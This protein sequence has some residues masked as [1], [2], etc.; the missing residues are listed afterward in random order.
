MPIRRTVEACSTV[1]AQGGGL[2]IEN[3]P[4]VTG[5]PSLFYMPEI[6]NRQT[7]TGAETGI[8]DQCIREAEAQK[9]LSMVRRLG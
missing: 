2:A 9:F 4:P 5:G 7:E 6:I 1:V 3:P 8:S